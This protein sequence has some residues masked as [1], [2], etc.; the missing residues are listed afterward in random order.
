MGEAKKNWKFYA[1]NRKEPDRHR[2][3]FGR[4][5]N[6]T[7]HFHFTYFWI[8]KQTNR[9][10]A[11]I[12]RKNAQYLRFVKIYFQENITRRSAAVRIAISTQRIHEFHSKNVADG[13]LKHSI[14]LPTATKGKRC[15]LHAQTVR[16]QR[17]NNTTAVPCEQHNVFNRLYFEPY[18]RNDEN[19]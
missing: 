11:N 1:D 10:C 7:L 4:L 16:S 19:G 6:F 13:L 2:L 8:H 12:A 15:V 18:E 14:A 5:P 17:N 9:S 3:F